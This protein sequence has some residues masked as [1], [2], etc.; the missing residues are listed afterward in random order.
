MILT[1]DV[2]NT[3]VAFG[4]W[5]GTGW[6]EHWR[7]HTDPEQTPDEYFVLFQ[8]LLR[9]SE[10]RLADIR[11]VVISSVVPTLTPTIVRV[12][13]RLTQQEP[14]LITHALITGLDP[15]TPIPPELGSDLLSNA[16]AAFHR[17]GTG[18][19]VVDFGTALSFTAVSGDGRILGVNIAPGLRSA[20]RSLSSSTSQLPIVDLTPPPH[21]LART[22]EHA[23]QGGIV[24]GYV[25]LIK[26]L[27]SRM[28]AEMDQPPRVFAT[29]GLAETFAPTAGCFDEVDQWLTL[30]GLRILADLNPA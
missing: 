4:I 23:I 28:S 13:R 5:D 18:A 16:V 29:G 27:I 20:V 1:I 17:S 3:N 24:F 2:G 21:A 15:D 22:T 30:D 9:L 10:H 12:S 25:G 14:L 7:L 6:I 26:E 8:N 11:R 19:I